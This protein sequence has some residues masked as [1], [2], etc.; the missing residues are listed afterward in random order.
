MWECGAR[1]YAPYVEAPVRIATKAEGPRRRDD[2]GPPCGRHALARRLLLPTSEPS[3][4]SG[5]Y[6]ALLTAPP[7]GGRSRWWSC[8][9]KPDAQQ[10][11]DLADEP[12]AK[13][14]HEGKKLVAIGLVAERNRAHLV[15]A[16]CLEYLPER[17]ID[18]AMNQQEATEEDDEHGDIHVAL[19]G[20]IDEAEEPSARHRLDAVFA[21]GE[22]R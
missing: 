16:D 6:G 2:G 8:N 7:R 10:V 3:E 22:R 11:R 4:S 17:R 12:A 9:S 21:V 15:F 14:Q 5:Q 20:Q 1:H 13:Q 18:D 19:I